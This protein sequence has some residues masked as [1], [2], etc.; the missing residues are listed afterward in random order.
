MVIRAAGEGGKVTLDAVCAEALFAKYVLQRAH[1]D[2]SR[3]ELMQPLINAVKNAGGPRA[4]LDAAGN[5]RLA[6]RCVAQTDAGL[7][8]AACD[9]AGPWR[10]R[11][12]KRPRQAR[13][14]KADAAAT[15]A[16]PPT[17]HRA[18][19]AARTAEAVAAAG[20]TTAAPEPAV[21]AAPKTAVVA[22]ELQSSKRLELQLWR[23]ASPRSTHVL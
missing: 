16:A 14:A 19:T 13:L 7:G 18:V 3:L 8:A 15:A 17:L 1:E 6:G 4:A 21:V 22:P 12:R 23:Q 10:K 9:A 20:A 11:G 2:V 5:L